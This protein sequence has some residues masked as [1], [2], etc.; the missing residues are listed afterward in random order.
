M[1]K[2]VAKKKE[3]QFKKVEIIDDTSYQISKVGDQIVMMK[4]GVQASLI[5]LK[6]NEKSVEFLYVITR[7]QFQGLGLAAKIV[8]W[9]FEWAKKEGLLVV[10]VCEYVRLTYLRKYP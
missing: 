4:D 2:E 6:L 3:P 7:S 5:N 8:K 10:P 9:G 1:Q